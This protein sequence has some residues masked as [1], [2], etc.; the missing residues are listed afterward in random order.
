MR[1]HTTDGILVGRSS[2][3]VCVFKGVPYAAPPVGPLRWKP[4]APVAPWTEPRQALAFGP[5]AF[6]SGPDG[7]ADLTTIGGAP[8]PFSEDCLTLNVWAPEAARGAPVMVWLHGGSGRMGAG[9]LPF[10]DGTAFARDGVVLVT[11]NFRL[12]HLGFFAHPSLTR[13]A[14]PDEPLGSYGIMDQAAALRW[15]RDNI[16]AFGGD[17]HRVTL[18]GESMGGFHTLALM[19]CPSARGLFHQAIVQSGGGWFPPNPVRKVEV[20][21]AAVASAAGLVGDTATADALRALP[22]ETLA[23]LPGEFHAII[24]GRFLPDELTPAIASGAVADIPLLIGVNSGEDS[25]LDYPGVFE[26]FRAGL[27]LK[28][29]PAITKLHGAS[30]DQAA[31]LYFRDATFTAPARWVARRRR[32]SPTYLYHFDYVSEA[33]R[34]AASRAGH[35]TDVGHVF[36]TL[37]HSP[38][39]VV[40]TVAD[41]AMAKVVHARWVAFARTGD[42]SLAAGDWPPYDARQDRWM[43]LDTPQG[44]TGSVLAQV[45]NWH[46]NRLRWL[47][48]LFTLKIRLDRLKRR[49]SRRAKTETI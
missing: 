26:R 22:P 44:R 18:F 4:P 39:G 13:E 7:V 47:I 34:G 23:P 12:G 40:P 25:L 38:D 5:S 9:S 46:D 19:A 24:D 37:D 45:L 10:Y 16:A 15:V 35:G 32:R 2:D 33:S 31:R 49:V 14:G 48:G 43:I 36:E 41:Q 42:P 17:P 11:V 21:G 8:P 1:V 29:I 20:Q 28:L 3:G 27:K 30:A 6:Q